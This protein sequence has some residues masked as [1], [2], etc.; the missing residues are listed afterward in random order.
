MAP[1][2]L[3]RQFV[4][5]ISRGIENNLPMVLIQ[6]HDTAIQWAA[7]NQLPPKNMAEMLLGLAV[8]YLTNAANEADNGKD[9]M[10]C[11]AALNRVKAAMI[12]LGCYV[13]DGDE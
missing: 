2:E 4:G 6:A 7:I 11:T 5:M 3:E 12:L 9:E 1:N 8:D 13:E 10:N